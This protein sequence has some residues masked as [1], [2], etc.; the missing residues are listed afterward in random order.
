MPS[1]V[2]FSCVCIYSFLRIDGE[3]MIES[4]RSTARCFLFLRM[5]VVKCAAVLLRRKRVSIWL[6]QYDSKEQ[7]K[8]KKKVRKKKE[9]VHVYISQRLIGYQR[10]MVF[11]ITI[12]SEQNILSLIG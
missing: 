3:N 9:E 7:E 5:I 1:I 6:R 12:N 2:F 10:E 11:T 4:I 8:K